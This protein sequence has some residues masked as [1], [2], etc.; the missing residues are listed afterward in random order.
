MNKFLSI[1][2]LVLGLALQNCTEN[3]K[4]DPDVFFCDAEEFNVLTNQFISQGDYFDEANGASSDE[5]YQGEHSCLVDISNPNGMIYIIKNPLAGET[6]NISVFR[7]SNNN[8]GRLLFLSSDKTVQ[9][10]QQISYGVK[11]KNGWE[12]LSLNVQLPWDIDTTMQLKIYIDNQNKDGKKAYFDNLKITR[13]FLKNNNKIQPDSLN[14]I[15]IQL[16]DQDYAALIAFRDKALKQEIISKELKKEFVGTLSYN[17]EH[18]RIALRLKGDWT[19]HLT[20][21]KWSFR[22]KIKNKAAFMGLKTFSIQAPEVRSFLNEW[23][24][25]KICEKEDLLTTKYEFLPVNINGV[26]FGIY[27]LE[28]HFEKQLLESKKRR[29]G[30]IL[31]FSEDGFWERN[32]Y[33]KEKG[34]EP[35]KPIFAEATI[36]PFKQKKTLKK[37]KLANQ[38]LI[39]QNLMLNYKNGS[40][41]VENFMDV[42]RLAKVYALMSIFNTD[43]AITWHNQRLY[44]NP[45]NSKLEFI[46]YDCFSGPGTEYSRTCEI[47]GN[48]SNGMNTI[49]NPMAYLVKNNFDDPV[50]LNYYLKHLKRFSSTIYL[51]ETLSRLNPAIDSLS[52][53]LRTDYKYYQYDK[54]LLK[55]NAK[56]IRGMLPEYETKVKDNSVKYQLKIERDTSC[57]DPLPFKN[58]S[59]K[60]HLENIAP[61]GNTTIS[62][63]NYHCKSLKVIGY[64][65]KQFVDSVILLKKPILIDRFLDNANTTRLNLDHKPKRIFYKVKGA[66][67]DS[68]Y[69]CKLITWPLPKL[70]IPSS[71]ITGTYLNE[72]SKIYSLSNDTL[73]FRSGKHTIK[74]NIVIPKNLQVNFE[75]GTELIFNNK[76]FLL[77]Y[78]PV[79]MIGTESNPIRISSADRTANGFTIIQAP[80]KSTLSYV[81]FN[82]LNTLN[83]DG[84]ELTGAVT[85]FESDVDI[86]NCIFNN[87]NCED[88]LNIVKSK[89]LLDNC[90][91]SNALLDGFD[92]DFCH[93]KVINSRFFNTGNDCLDFSG[94]TIKIS[95]CDI[96]HSG[97][98]GISCGEKSTISIENVK[99]KDA[100]IGVASKDESSAIVNNLELENCIIGYSIFQK[101][102]EYGGAE[103]VVKNHKLKNVETISQC[104]EGSTI[105]IK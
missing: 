39:A 94:S 99:I 53:M 78:S 38:F 11:D 90:T 51:N 81:I 41:D 29:E 57:I 87:N 88:G 43:H 61:N 19:D 3:K 25:H 64:S 40:P 36:L 1:F 103:V 84:W 32:L 98:K 34:T 72:N 5:H 15:K 73:I 56:K 23:V 26:N 18:Y 52:A 71:K 31:K 102:P 76:T 49:T 95:D 47:F 89:F 70:N 17:N 100:V 79:K 8:I 66:Q 74:E 48:D 54:N 55:S 77:S 10:S 45:I 60:A 21:Y 24:V 85:F 12:H 91:I 44:Y 93:G 7:K 13:S 69:K 9:K 14:Q 82:G 22:I 33:L 6:F 67:K 27:N 62:L 65:T 86:T 101:K 2:L 104:E 58:F 92:G 63:S 96:K 30:P 46:V 97:D 80:Q 75:P 42:E 105:T 68:I 28:E 35:N 83:I 59:L 4:T 16:L 37:Q 50:F 20:G